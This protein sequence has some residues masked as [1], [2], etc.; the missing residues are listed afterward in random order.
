MYMYVC[1]YVCRSHLGTLI[2]YVWRAHAIVFPVGACTPNYGP[3]VVMY[4]AMLWQESASE[5]ECK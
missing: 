5:Y 4:K 1:M 2:M 3:I